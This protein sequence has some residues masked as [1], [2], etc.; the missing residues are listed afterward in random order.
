MENLTFQ[1]LEFLLAMA[2]QKQKSLYPTG[3]LKKMADNIVAKLDH[4]IKRYE[5]AGVRDAKY[6]A[7]WDENR[8]GI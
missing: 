4:A 1:E 8:L 2:K 6:P 7:A 5:D 3:T